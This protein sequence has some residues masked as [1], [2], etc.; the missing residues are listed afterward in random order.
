MS[1]ATKLPAT[2]QTMATKSSTRPGREWKKP[3][4]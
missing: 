4:R 3:L 1:I 2:D